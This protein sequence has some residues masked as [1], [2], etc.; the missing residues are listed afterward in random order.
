MT[1]EK[2]PDRMRRIMREKRYSVKR[3]AQKSGV[4]AKT[5]WAL[6]SGQNRPMA[7]TLRILADALGVTMDELFGRG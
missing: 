4:P 7:Y 6:R 5:I 3:L 2:F 1:D